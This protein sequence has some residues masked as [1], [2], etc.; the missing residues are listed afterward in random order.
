[1]NN[2]SHRTVDHSRLPLEPIPVLQA[3]AK[4]A[5]LEDRKK[6]LAEIQA[7]PL[8]RM[9]QYIEE[10]KD[11]RGQ[12]NCCLCV[13]T[14][15]P[16]DS[17]AWMTKDSWA[18]WHFRIHHWNL[19]KPMVDQRRAVLRSLSI[20]STHCESPEQSAF[21]TAEEPANP[22]FSPETWIVLGDITSDSPIETDRE[23]ERIVGFCS[24]G[25][26]YS[27]PGPIMIQRFVVVR[28]GSKSCLCI[29]IHTYVDGSNFKDAPL[30]QSI[31]QSSFTT[32]A[33]SRYAGRGC[34]NQTDQELFAILHSSKEIPAPETDET[35]I[36]LSPIRMKAEHP[37]TA[38]PHSARI[39]FGRAYEVDHDVPVRPLGL[40]HA[41][42][43][44][45]L[46]SQFENHVFKKES[47]NSGVSQAAKANEAE[48]AQDD[49]KVGPA[50]MAIVKEMR[51]NIM[52]VLGEDISPYKHTP[53]K[54]VLESAGEVDTEWSIFEVLRNA[55]EFDTEWSIS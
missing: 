15:P 10:K 39:H 8:D 52:D 29:G 44:E 11:I 35:G 51:Q 36:T 21:K 34:A 7:L 28:E 43:M 25:T 53:P 14:T 27:L 45:T 9:V 49:A 20:Q 13:P 5:Y 48:V 3:K 19:Y 38:L 18:S 30:R 6:R 42:S 16:P 54:E 12:V 50:D 55:G 47:G 37:S 17:K 22:I 4:A 2:Y 31:S 1:L 40:I 26:H 33:N 24:F 32:N 46:L 23:I 41:G